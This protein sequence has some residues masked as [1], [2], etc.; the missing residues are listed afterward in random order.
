MV[1]GILIALQINDWN[2]SH[3]LEKLEL[4]LLAEVKNGLS[5][6]LQKIEETILYEKD[7]INS[8]NEVIRWL[9]SDGSFQNSLAID[10][11]KTFFSS[12]LTFK[13]GPYETLKLVGLKIV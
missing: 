7:V 2:E 8:Q 4:E 12:D 10:F 5:F 9:Q 11:L 3:K 13:D 1:I 6:D